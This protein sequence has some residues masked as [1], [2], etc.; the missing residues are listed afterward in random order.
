MRIRPYRQDS[1]FEAQYDIWLSATQELPYAWGSNLANARGFGSH[2]P[3]LPG[4][5]LFA[6]RDDGTIVGYVGVNET[7]PWEGLGQALPFGFPWTWPVDEATEAGLYSLMLASL[8]T[9][10]PGARI[11]AIVQSFRRSWVRQHAFLQ[12]RGWLEHEIAPIMA[13]RVMAPTIR[14]PITQRIRLGEEESLAAT[15]A[16]D[17]VMEPI[18]ATR[19]RRRIEQ[20]W[21]EVDTFWVAPGTGA[22]QFEMRDDRAEV[23]LFRARPDALDALLDEL[24]L[25]TSERGASTIYFTLNADQVKRLEQLRARGFEQ[26]DADVYV[27]QRIA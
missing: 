25:R 15:V 7:M 3:R 19:L 2:V 11:D 1:D 22:F 9:L 16:L 17:P 10:F 5:R 27:I 23:K 4:A 8:P 26:R 18:D 20:A 14:S 12:Q 13:K 21:F 24:V 6:E